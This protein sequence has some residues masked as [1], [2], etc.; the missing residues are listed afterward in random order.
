[1]IIIFIELDRQT[2]LMMKLSWLPFLC[3]LQ[4]VKYAVSS[5]SP[6]WPSPKLDSSDYS[7]KSLL[8]LDETFHFSVI[9]KS[10]ANP[11]ESNIKGLSIVEKAVVRY[12]NII[13]PPPASVGL[14]KS[15]SINIDDFSVSD[16]IGKLENKIKFSLFLSKPSKIKQ[17]STVKLIV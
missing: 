9:R 6:V 7:I 3:F 2:N 15:C 5:E 12:E 8:Y 4:Y 13:S 17:F 1:M 16:S 14:I 11:N 10:W